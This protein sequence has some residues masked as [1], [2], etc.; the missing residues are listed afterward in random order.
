MSMTIGPVHTAW[1]F[2][3]GSESVRI[4]RVGQTD[5]AQ[6]LLVNG[7]GTECTSTVL[8][9]AMECVRH[10]SEIERRLVGKGFRLEH[11][12]TGDRR[13]GSDRRH[14]PRGGDRRQ[15]LARVV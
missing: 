2:T 8:P 12:A 6:R 4:I 3:R 14:A 7:P 1:L 11:F 10:Q 5:G 13:R 15:H 9:D